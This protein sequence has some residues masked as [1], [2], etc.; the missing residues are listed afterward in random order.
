MKVL[1]VNASPH[2]D[3]CT[4]YAL[5]LVQNE[6]YNEGIETELLNIGHINIRGCLDCGYCNR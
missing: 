1:I 4:G 6:L 2:E 5:S 3:E